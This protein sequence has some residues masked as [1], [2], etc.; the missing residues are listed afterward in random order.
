MNKLTLEEQIEEE[1]QDLIEENAEFIAIKNEKK[2]KRLINIRI[3][4]NL[5]KILIKK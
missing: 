5:K 2:K 1:I 4:R 3:L